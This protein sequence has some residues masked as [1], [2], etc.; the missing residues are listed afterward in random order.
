MT[1]PVTRARYRSMPWTPLQQWWK[2]LR[3]SIRTRRQRSVRSLRGQVT[4]DGDIDASRVG[5]VIED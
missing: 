4:W 2:E 5:R 3:S 1:Q